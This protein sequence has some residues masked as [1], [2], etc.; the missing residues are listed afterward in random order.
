MPLTTAYLA[1]G[2]NI[3]DR[4]ATMRKALRELE[5]GGGVLVTR[6]SG[7]Y[8]NRAVG[9]GEAEPFLNAV[10]EVKT[11]L[12]AEA[13]L[14]R[15]L[16]AETRLGRTRTG[17]WAPR[18]IDIDILLFGGTAVQNPRLTVPHPRIAERDFVLR[19]LADLDPELEIGGQTVRHLLAAVGADALTRE[20]ARVRPE[21]G[22]H[23]IAAV[24]ENGV[25]GRDGGLPWALP[26]DWE[27]FLKKTV[28]GVLVMGR[29][30]FFEMTGRRY[31]VVSANPALFAEDGVEVVP[32]TPSA[33]SAAGRMGGPVWICGGE[34]IYAE[35]LPRADTL[36]LTLVRREPEGDTWFP[37]WR[38]AFPR[39]AA[40]VD[41]ADGDTAYTFTV[42]ER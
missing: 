19:P 1:L 17:V 37:E 25:I 36:H 28:G 10:A 18:T 12:G 7:A 6:T 8:A 39:Q 32:D 29:S 9:M 38:D 31:V 24:A 14:D 11:D 21:P 42:L 22:V 27:V 15:C 26:E 40:A 13:L 34:R 2:G 30:S 23:G 41:S 16:D 3:G 20:D 4:L 33:L 5:A 35:A